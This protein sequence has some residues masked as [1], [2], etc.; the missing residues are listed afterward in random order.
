VS[1][2]LLTAGHDF[3]WA[4]IHPSRKDHIIALERNY[5][6]KNMNKYSLKLDEGED[7]EEGL[8]SL[9][10]DQVSQCKRLPILNLNAVSF[11]IPGDEGSK[12]KQFDEEKNL[13]NEEI[14]KKRAEEEAERLR[15]KEEE[16]KKEEQKQKQK[17]EG[18]EPTGREQ[19]KPEE[20]EKKEEEKK[21]EEEEQKQTQLEFRQKTYVEWQEEEEDED[22]PSR[23][24]LSIWKLNGGKDPQ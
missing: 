11:T 19:K 7:S 18:V 23:Y 5:F 14:Q 24:A 1:A 2:Y 21:D 22:P 10:D 4:C 6:P 15:R 3:L 12:R 9:K 16:K 13:I 20:G 17:E 8:P